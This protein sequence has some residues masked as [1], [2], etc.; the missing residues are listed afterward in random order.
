VPF[1]EPAEFEGSKGDIPDAIVDLL[2]ADV[3]ANAD[4]GDVDPLPVSPDAPV[5]TDV[6]HFEAVRIC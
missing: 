6:A 1:E 2:E 4:V 5:G 3:F